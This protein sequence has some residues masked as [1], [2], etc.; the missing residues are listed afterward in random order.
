MQ[1]EAGQHNVM[2]D[3]KHKMTFHYI[4]ANSIM[5]KV[6]K[7]KIYCDTCIDEIDKVLGYYHCRECKVDRCRDCSIN[8]NKMDLELAENPIS[9]A[10]PLID[11]KG[12]SYT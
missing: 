5:Q 4:T 8:E 7:H 12:T 9:V 2:D 10:T 3:K 11:L 6:D 1:E